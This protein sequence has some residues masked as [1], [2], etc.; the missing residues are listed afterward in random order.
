MAKTFIIVTYLTTALVGAVMG[1][2]LATVGRKYIDRPFAG[3]AE[4]TLA[5]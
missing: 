2:V 5:D 4:E 3:E 1:S